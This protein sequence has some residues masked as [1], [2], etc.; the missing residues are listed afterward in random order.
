MRFKTF[1]IAII[2]SGIDFHISRANFCN[3]LFDCWLY[4][5]FKIILAI[6]SLLHFVPYI[7]FPSPHFHSHIQ[8]HFPCPIFPC[9]FFSKFFF[10]TFTLLPTSLLF[11]SSLYLNIHFFNKNSILPSQ[12][13]WN[14]DI[15]LW[16]LLNRK[17]KNK[18]WMLYLN[19]C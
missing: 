18:E 3:F 1:L 6:I 10:P 12:Q 16:E 13:I 9:F 19:R 5:F 4:F 14:R 8:V 7:L 17:N 15:N 11:N 2:I